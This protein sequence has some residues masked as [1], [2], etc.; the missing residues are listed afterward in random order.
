MSIESILYTAQATA[1]G[2]RE[3]H[4]TSSDR[5][6]DI[7]LSTPKELG[8]TGGTGTNPEQLFAAG[9]S[10]CFLGALRYVAGQEHVALPDTAAVTGRVGIGAVSTGFAIDVAL[11]VSLPG[12]NREV[13]DDLVRKAHVVCPYSHATRNNIN[14]A[15]ILA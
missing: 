11:T 5:S 2:G 10:A 12:V 9:Y 3:G 6:L 7:V 4:A 14:V 1:V 8:G 15:L 13:A